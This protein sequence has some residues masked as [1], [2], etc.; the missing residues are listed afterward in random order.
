[1]NVQRMGSVVRTSNAS[2]METIVKRSTAQKNVNRKVKREQ[3]NVLF[4][5]T[6]TH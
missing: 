6:M 3:M 1:M 2:R 5:K 4:P